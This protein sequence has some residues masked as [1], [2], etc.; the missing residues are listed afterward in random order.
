[1]LFKVQKVALSA[2]F[3]RTIH[4]SYRESQ[5]SFMM[6]SRWKLRTFVNHDGFTQVLGV[7]FFYVY[8]MIVMIVLGP[9]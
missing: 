1:M 2:A 8:L 3:F 4:I 9:V 6:V 7:T 5:K